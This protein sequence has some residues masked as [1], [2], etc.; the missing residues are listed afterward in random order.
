M[1]QKT[2]K[3]LYKRKKI[4]VV[5]TTA[6]L[7]VSAFVPTVAEAIELPGAHSNLAMP[8]PARDVDKITLGDVQSY[9]NNSDIQMIPVDIPNG[10]KPAD[11]WIY[12]S[13]KNR[14]LIPINETI[15]ISGV[16]RTKVGEYEVTLSPIGWGRYRT[17]NGLDSSHEPL[18][19]GMV[20]GKWKVVPAT[21]SP[22]SLTIKS[23]KWSDKATAPKE[24]VIHKNNMFVNMPTEWSRI[25]D[26]TDYKIKADSGDLDFS[27]VNEAEGTY[28]IKLSTQG[29]NKLKAVNPESSGYI[30]ADSSISNGTLIRLSDK[31]AY[32]G[33]VTRNV[34]TALP[35]TISISL[36]RD[37]TVPSDWTVKYDNPGV[38]QIDYNVPLSYFDVVDFNQAEEKTF[39][40]K[41]KDSTISII[42][43]LNTGKTLEA[44]KVNMGR[45]YTKPAGYTANASW[46]LS[47]YA[48]VVSG[49]T[50]QALITGKTNYLSAQSEFDLNLPLFGNTTTGID[51]NGQP[52]EYTSLF[53]AP[54][55]FSVADKSNGKITLSDNP[56]SSLQTQ[57]QAT[58][59]AFLA[60][61]PTAGYKNL[62][63]QQLADYKG[64]QAFAIT[65]AKTTD[66]N[67]APMFKISLTTN[68]QPVDNGYL[69]PYKGSRD[70]AVM[71]AVSDSRFG[72]NNYSLTYSGYTDVDSVRNAYGLE[73][74][75]VLDSS[76]E[77]FIYKYSLTSKQQLV[78]AYKQ[79]WNGTTL[80][81]P[82]QGGLSFGVYKTPDVSDS[83]ITSNGKTYDALDYPDAYSQLNSMGKH[84]ETADGTIRNEK[85]IKYVQRWSY[86]QEKNRIKMPYIEKYVGSELPDKIEA[87]VPAELKLPATWVRNGDKV[88]I[89]SSDIEFTDY[90]DTANRFTITLNDKGLH[91]LADSNKGVYSISSGIV[92]E[93]TLVN[94][95]NLEFQSTPS[96]NFG[97]YTLGTNSDNHMVQTD[98][99]NALDEDDTDDDTLQILNATDGGAKVTAELG[100]IKNA[101]GKTVA[102]QLVVSTDATEVS[103]D[104]T[105]SDNAG[106]VA[107]PSLTDPA[108]TSSWTLLS[109]GSASEVFTVNRQ[110]VLSVKYPHAKLTMP[111]LKY[112]GTYTA[113]LT[114]TLAS[115]PDANN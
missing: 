21:A 46:A 54:E 60:E 107:N 32:I 34:N 50:W 35:A 39:D 59:D 27:D 93:G 67:S 23:Q 108:P 5:A 41:F 82:T 114:Y 31:V 19:E 84:S 10:M 79:V 20:N 11:S 45:V 65:V 1:E 3:K 22:S 9:A 33:S 12:T 72:N 91:N 102:G 78:D 81:T 28:N 71:Y 6:L 51:N 52:T 99:S 7:L 25:G 63:V 18:P 8:S 100:E 48:P 113:P 104:D 70:S 29:L 85:T 86:L 55:G 101:Q 26:S 88:S 76:Y 75:G 87:T 111:E 61:N 44:D 98:Y 4:W 57:L 89:P 73:H 66:T 42:N 109:G 62:K 30:V 43:G 69:G 95:A 49:D 16:D 74:A 40:V 13:Q 83:T 68:G 15:D 47:N 64:R 115:T 17:A 92:Q 90:E 14:Y 97:D 110:G 105:A 37:Y 36:S 56:V 80:G 2:R 24:W 58:L 112:Q 53:I 38:S 103:R 77:G 96:Y 94:R 106:V